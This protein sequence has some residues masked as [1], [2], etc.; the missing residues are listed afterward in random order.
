M[1]YT[2]NWEDKNVGTEP[3]QHQI[4]EI[5]LENR[6]RDKIKVSFK[7]SAT[8]NGHDDF[9]PKNRNN[10]G[11]I[12]VGG[13]LIKPNS[14]NDYTFKYNSYFGS[15]DKGTPTTKTM[16]GEVSFSGISMGD[17]SLDIYYKNDRINESNTYPDLK[18]TTGVVKKTKIGTLSIPDWNKYNISYKKGYTGGDVSNVP[19]DISL[20]EGLVYRIPSATLVDNKNHY[21][22]KNGYSTSKNHDINTSSPAVDCGEG[23]TATA[24]VTYYGCWKPQT[25]NYHFFPS[26]SFKS[27]EEFKSITKTYTYTNNPINLPNLNKSKT[28]NSLTKAEKKNA[29]KEGYK[30]NGWN[31]SRKN[32]KVTDLECSLDSDT[33]FYIDW[34]LIKYNVTFDYGFNNI[35]S[36]TSGLTYKKTFNFSSLLLNASD[37]SIRPG[38]KLIGWSYDKT[39]VYLPNTARSS[40]KVSFYNT[41]NKV[42]KLQ[43]GKT[44]GDLENGITLYAVW[45]YFTVSYVVDSDGKTF[46]LAVPYVFTDNG[47]K[48]S[49]PYIFDGK[50]WKI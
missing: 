2:F 22:F 33:N 19:N 46:R 5:K 26:S 27:K 8:S 42:I 47:W 39:N 4:L 38:Y 48:F 45:E 31:S 11:Y 36:T 3:G 17:T 1:A 35:K 32:F 28:Y 18:C 50:S 9:G 44:N 37:I 43:S 16:K 13:H 6:D 21:V 10:Y 41:D 25:Y 40:G 34:E 7:F 20:Y 12:W 14:S 23:R 30:F 24:D 49:I 29:Y 15:L